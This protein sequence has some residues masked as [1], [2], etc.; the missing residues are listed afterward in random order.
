MDDGAPGL[1]L[2]VY[3]AT[4]GGR[5]PLPGLTASWWAGAHLYRA[6]GRLDAWHPAETWADALG[7]L[8]R[9]R[10]DRPIA[11]IQFWGHG[12]WGSARV[13]GEV[14]DRAA[15]MPAHP[16]R[17]RLEAI[18]ARLV[19]GDGLWWFRTCETFG[20]RAGHDLARAWAD[21]FG[22]RAAGHT[23]VIGPWQ[24]GL[25]SLAPGAVP[26]WPADEGLVAGT[27]GAPVK[28]AWSRP[29]APHTV[30]CLAG[31]VPQGW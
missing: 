2:M 25:H 27:P 21:F 18:R 19:P 15:L 31:R 28:A 22:A 13:A 26:D 7:W 9:V 10:P 1:R 14:L 4:Q 23:F 11:E 20:A 12:H 17:R 24:S 5:G 30:T 8:A 6:L 16:H 3:D 29:G